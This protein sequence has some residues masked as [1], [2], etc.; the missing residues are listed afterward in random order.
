MLMYWDQRGTD[1]SWA[2]MGDHADAFERFVEV[3]GIPPVGSGLSLGHL[4]HV[5]LDRPEVHEATAHYLEPMDF[6][7]A[8]LTGTP[9]GTQNTMFTAQL[10]D[11]RTLGATGYDP[12]LLA[13]AGIDAGKL[14]PLVAVDAVVGPLLGEV[15]EETGLPPSVEVR[16]GINDSTAGALAAGVFAPG[17][18]GLA[19][20]T[21]AVL[22]DTVE[23]KRGDLDAELVSMPSSVPDRYLAWAENGMA[24][25]AV[26]HGMGLLGGSFAHL[27][28]ALEASAARGRRRPVPALAVGLHRPG[29]RP[30]RPGRVP[31]RVPAHHPGGPH[32]GHGRGHGPQP[33]LAPARGRGVHRTGHGRAGLLRGRRP[34][35]GVVPDRGRRP[36]PPGVDAGPPRGR[37]GHGRR[38]R[39]AQGGDPEA[40][41]QVTAVHEPRPEAHE[42]H[43]RMQ[44]QFQAA[45]EALKPLHAALNG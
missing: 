11:N 39:H 33:G 43:G 37:R 25:K 8:R 28:T 15:A 17:R 32:P 31:Q 24:G 27:E 14:P 22:L 19:M 12:E 38:R 6:V 44:E 1:H 35:T 26:E 18:G 5:Q 21:T 29:R 3:H 16:A 42:A 40:A 13:L 7:V 23:D 30:Q 34:L 20:G 41:P 2:I 10:V 36:R 9:V 45:F 4:L